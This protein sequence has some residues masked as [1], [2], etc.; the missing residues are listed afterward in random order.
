MIAF[1][2]AGLLGSGFVRAFSR[3]GQSVQV[4]NRTAARA[5]ALASLPGVRA[6]ADA[7]AA[8]RGA[9]RVHLCLSDDAAVDSVLDAAR[10]GLAAGAVIVDHTTTSPGGAAERTRRWTE[11]G[12]PFLHA[13]VFMGPQQAEEAQGIMLTSG[14]RAVFERLE[15]ELALMTGKLIHVGA[16]PHV[17]AAYKLMGNSFLIALTA[18]IA[19]VAALARATGLGPADVERIFSF[20]NPAATLAG[21]VKRVLSAGALPPSWDLAMA[22]KDARLMVDAARAGGAPLLVIPAVAAV[23]DRWIAAGMGESD[24]T[25][26]AKDA[27]G[28]VGPPGG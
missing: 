19:D 14:D 4:W 20:F 23:M 2:G 27:V 26:V 11:R 25:I 15:P 3:R 16:E 17:A 10:P 28:E 9:T 7:A 21:R 18:G 12:F 1:L 5:Q 8:V 6:E 22:R 13:P 24:W